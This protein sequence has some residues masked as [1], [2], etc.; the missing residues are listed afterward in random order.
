[1]KEKEAAAAPPSDDAPVATAPAEP[2]APV[3]SP[4]RAQE[5]QF[6]QAL[7]VQAAPAAPAVPASAAPPTLPADVSQFYLPLANPVMPTGA[8]LFYQPR[9]LGVA[10]VLFFD[11][12]RGL[13]PK[14]TH[15]LLAEV[16]ANGQINWATAERLAAQPGN[17]PITPAQWA[18]VPEAVNGS[19]KVKALQKAFSDFLYNSARLVLRENA[20]LQLMSE[21]GEDAQTFQ[22]R[23]RA[24]AAQRAAAEVAQER[25]KFEPKFAKLGAKVPEGVGEQQGSSLLNA[26][27]P[28]SWLG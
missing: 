22:Q 6:K 25:A 18:E 2:P 27:N 15:R 11:K 20:D 28:F 16:P 1:I 3:A 13:S 26:I 8:T 23:C 5:Q 14:Q 9:L 4:V 10:E 21:V 17:A 24:A 19:R 12:K 7:Q